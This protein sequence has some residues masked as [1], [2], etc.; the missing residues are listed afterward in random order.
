MRRI[1]L[2]AFAIIVVVALLVS[3]SSHEEKTAASNNT[4][5]DQSSVAQNTP[6]AG[7]IQFTAQDMQGTLRNSSEWIGKQPVVINVWGTWCPPCRRE[8]P[9]LVRLHKEYEQKGVQMIGLTV[10]RN[11]TPQHVIE[12]AQ[13]HDMNWQMLVATQE[14]AQ[15]YQIFSVP[16]T[17]FLDK[18]GN[19]VKVKDANG[20]LV[21]RF[22]G[23]RSYEVFKAAFERIAST[24]GEQLSGL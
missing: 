9:E 2:H 5:A 6:T 18:E 7:T 19:V 16:T 23:P 17:I 21:D 24:G 20:Q 13:Q 3:C 8:I 12:F 4:R 11:E 1:S 14:F 22:V 15:N 10:V